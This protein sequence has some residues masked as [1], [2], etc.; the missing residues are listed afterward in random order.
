MSQTTTV[1]ARPERLWVNMRYWHEWD[2]ESKKNIRAG[3]HLELRDWAHL[4]DGVFERLE[5]TIGQAKSLRRASRE[6]T[7]CLNRAS[8]AYEVTYVS[9]MSRAE[10]EGA[11]A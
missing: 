1:S 3:A 7:R 2:N 6:F 11:L 8:G 4:Q 9:P 10:F 5:I